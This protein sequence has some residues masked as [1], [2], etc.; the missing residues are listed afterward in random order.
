[1]DEFGRC[2][3]PDEEAWKE[4][5]KEKEQAQ[6][7]ADQQMLELPPLPEE[8]GVEVPVVPVLDDNLSEDMIREEAPSLGERFG[9]QMA[10][11]LLKGL[12][13]LLKDNAGRVVGGA[14]GAGLGSLAL[15]PVGGLLGGAVGGLLG[16][17]FQDALEERGIDVDAILEGLRT[18]FEE[19]IQPTLETFSTFITETLMPPLPPPP[20]TDWTIT[21]PERSL[22]VCTLPV[23]LL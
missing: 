11:G 16:S 3:N 5:I 6:K 4:A 19:E 18:T 8:Q 7:E 22:A 13:Q 12:G 2:F 23:I 20:P 15:G 9:M 1:M 14:L 10:D 21:P 17:A